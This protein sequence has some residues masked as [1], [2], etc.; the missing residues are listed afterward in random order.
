M[1]LVAVDS[2]DAP[3]E[4]DQGSQLCRPRLRNCN[5]V[6]TDPVRIA[7]EARFP[8]FLQGLQRRE[9]V[10]AGDGEPI[11][12]VPNGAR[13]HVPRKHPVPV[14]RGKERSFVDALAALGDIWVNDAFSVSHRAHASSEG[15]GHKLPAYAGYGGRA[16]GR[17]RRAGGAAAA[18]GCDRGRRQG[19]NEARSAWQ[20]PRQGRHADHRRRHRQHL[21]RGARTVDRKIAVR[22]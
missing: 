4:A 5:G 15:L 3:P 16:S 14:R 21:S 20:S 1:I 9:S 22:A 7:A 12:F 8:A 10:K 2:H 13:N 11:R 6:P 17:H 19:V 18:G